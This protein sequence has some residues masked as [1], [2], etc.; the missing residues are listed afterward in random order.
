VTPNGAACTGTNIACDGAENNGASRR[1]AAAVMPPVWLEAG[2]G[3]FWGGRPLKIIRFGVGAERFACFLQDDY[4]S[5]DR[6]AVLE[7]DDVVI[8][9]ADAAARHF[10]ADRPRMCGLL[11]P[12]DRP[13]A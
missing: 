6:H 7:V 10:F 13:P 3:R 4:R 5:A 9:Q 1:N 11:M 12:P 2:P 8:E